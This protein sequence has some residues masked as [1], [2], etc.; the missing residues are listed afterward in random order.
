VSLG[1]LLM[2]KLTAIIICLFI[3]LSI[4]QM[5]AFAAIKL[6]Y[7]GKVHM[8][9]GRAV[10]LIIND[11]TL[12]PKVPPIIMQGT[13]LVPARA[14]FEEMGA[15]VTWN[16][17]AQQVTVTSAKNTIVLVINSEFAV[18][19]GKKEKLLM[20]AKI[21][22]ENTMIPLRFVSEKMGLDVKWNSASYE[23]KI[24]E[25]KT[26][27]DTS[28]DNN[29]NTSSGVINNISFET[30]SEKT[31]VTI[32][33]DS[34]I[35][36]YSKLELNEEGKSFRL[37][38]DIPEKSINISQLTIPV[39]DGRIT[40]IRS[41]QYQL[42]PKKVRVVLDM[43]SKL[44]Y[45]LDFTQDKKALLVSIG[46]SISQEDKLNGSQTG[47]V[48]DYEYFNSKIG[49]D[50]TVALKDEGEKI[51]VTI[52]KNKSQEIKVQRGTK[53]DSVEIEINKAKFKED[54]FTIP[55]SS[56]PV[57]SL[58]AEMIDAQK[59]KITII[60]SSQVPYQIYDDTGSLNIYIYKEG[61]KNIRY[62]NSGAISTLIISKADTSKQVTI[63][64][65][66][67]KNEAKILLPEGLAD[68]QSGDM[69][70]N[71]EMLKSFEIS[72]END[73]GREID[74]KFSVESNIS[75]SVRTD[76]MKNIYVYFFARDKVKLPDGDILIAID[77]GHG[78]KDPGAVYKDKNGVV[79]VEEADLNLDI[80]CRLN[81]ILTDLGI[82]TVMTRSK[83]E[84][85]ELHQ[86][87]NMANSMKADLFVSIHN[88]WIDST[89]VAGT[90]T[91]YFPY[92]D[93][94]SGLTSKRFAEIV[95]AEML[96]TINTTD[97]KIVSR[98][99]L[100]VL[101][102]TEMPAILVECGFLS[103]DSDR[104]KL[105]TEKYR[106]QI[107]QALYTAVIRA[108]GEIEK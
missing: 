88:N 1:G 9:D 56:S 24:S 102:S 105:T 84:Y 70:I 13:T 93:A 66:T 37:V 45:S 40:K 30:S 59:G 60:T 81:K 57:T 101:N 11:K 108:L 36:D 43:T 16:K 19:N 106:E 42:S 74:I 4:S 22:N 6:V 17:S 53:P 15:K 61:Y 99:N 100:V 79:K 67:K 68:I 80:A 86:R 26:E 82:P 98:P 34:S 64:Q 14:V 50:N 54:K 23:I 49:E 33:S 91:L 29:T 71:D 85:V 48:E 12:N 72:D 46:G 78:G 62:E 31:L 38:I 58:M 65:G 76:T 107:A 21:I 97:R 63:E 25:K 18:V 89:S 2:K 7:D 51:C 3:I 35:S 10:S 52:N 28:Q 96:R 69:Y 87:P 75:Y 94:N 20:P 90:M 41:A 27:T 104:G 103:N 92:D 55:I 77:A 47:T 73:S 8:Y 5:S 95:Q 44:S 39:D 83:D 32:Q